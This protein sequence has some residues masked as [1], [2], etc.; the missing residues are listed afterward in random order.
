MATGYQFQV[1]GRPFGAKVHDTWG[2]AARDAIDA[3]YGTWVSPTQVRL[4]EQAE[5]ARVPL[6]KAKLEPAGPAKAPSPPAPS[7]PNHG[8]S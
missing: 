3:G 8:D 6:P 2:A 5:I 4:D 7:R 1:D